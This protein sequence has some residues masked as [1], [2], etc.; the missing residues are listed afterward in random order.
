MT[1]KNKLRIGIVG[2]G[3]IADVH[4]QA[5]SQS[6]NAE[7]VS[8]FSRSEIKANSF[9]KKYRIKWT[10]DWERFIS[11]PDIHA[12]SICTPSGNHL[13]YGESAAIAGK[14][15]IVEKPIEVTLE[16]A[17][18]LIDVCKE[19][20]VQLAVIFQSRFMPQIQKLRH[21]IDNHIIGKLFM[22][23]AY[24]KWFRSQ[25]YYDSGAWRGTTKLDGGGTLMNQS[26]HTIDLLQWIMGGVES[27]Y[28][29]TG[30]FTHERLEVE[31][32]AVATLRFKS[33]AI[34]V[35]EGSTSIQPGRPRRIELHGEKG[36]AIIDDDSVE[37]QPSGDDSD[38]ENQDDKNEQIGAGSGSPLA[39]FSIDPHKDQ[40]NAIAKAIENNEHPPI[41]GEESIKSLAIILA[42][43]ESSKTNM[44]VKLEDFIKSEI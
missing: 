9:G 42:I 18:R 25:E 11:D 41:A 39:G 36:T 4:A 44:P 22:G 12:V 3:V 43:Y 15:V 6:Q 26:I 19:E 38:K 1:E 29:Q 14:H 10:T 28:G 7:L 21:Q 32:N 5:I 13:D 20:K 31:D 33:G 27:V 35:I 24:I 17:R 23:D 2:C 34:G 30:T 37:I 8:A 16:R 40:F